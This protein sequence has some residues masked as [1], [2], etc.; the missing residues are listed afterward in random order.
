MALALQCTKAS[1]K[2]AHLGIQS[3]LRLDCCQQLAVACIFKLLRAVAYPIRNHQGLYFIACTWWS[4]PTYS[5]G[6]CTRT[7]IIESLRHCQQAKGL[8]L[9][10]YCLMTNHLHLIARAADDYQLSG[11]MR[12]F[13]KY[14]AKRIFENLHA[15]PQESRRFWLEWLLK[16]PAA[17]TSA[18]PTC[19]SGS[20]PA[21]TSSC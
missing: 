1:C 3:S 19:S 10:A 5:P 2:L 21:T 15:N 4:G 8:E 20:S 6:R 7:F 13:K 14:T 11:I 17:S 9:F 16:T 18:T 12:D